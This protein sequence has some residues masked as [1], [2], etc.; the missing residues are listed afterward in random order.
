MCLAADA[1]FMAVIVPG[2]Q[3]ADLDGEAVLFLIGMRV[4][5]LAAVGQWWPVARAMGGM[6]RELAA[7]PDSGLLAARSWWWGR[8]I[9]FQQYWE[10]TDKLIA[11]ANDPGRRHR[12]AWTD[13]FRRVGLDEGGAVG[14][15]HETI[16]LAPGSVECIYGNMPR[17]G[18]GE[19]VGI[20]P[21]IGHRRT[22][23]E[24]LANVPRDD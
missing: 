3:T 4:N 7:T 1:W 2:R 20:V 8:N 17:F 12:P 9:A 6:L 16:R 21:A 24:R 14:I 23:A 5:R 15:W 11:Y 10:S 18:I 19:A 13:F 22:A